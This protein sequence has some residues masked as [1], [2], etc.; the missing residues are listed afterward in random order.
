MQG[1]T[2]I[3]CPPDKLSDQPK[4]L[5]AGLLPDQMP[6]MGA[7]APLGAERKQAADGRH[8]DDMLCTFEQ[9]GIE[10]GLGND[11]SRVQAKFGEQAG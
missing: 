3:R 7:R 1:G 9:A 6:K 2:D 8:W 10:P 11:R 5:N 4:H